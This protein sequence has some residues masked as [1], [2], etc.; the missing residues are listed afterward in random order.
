V[1]INVGSGF[2]IS[3]KALANLI[4]RLTGFK[5]RMAW[6]TSKPDGQ[7]RRRL[8]TSKAEVEFGF[9]AKTKLE[10]GLRKTIEWY[11]SNENKKI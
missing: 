1:P 10:E 4:A 5:G 3:I 9:K 7:P 11:L 2:E 6:D 8:D